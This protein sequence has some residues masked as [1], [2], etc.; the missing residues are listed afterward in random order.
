MR[1]ALPL[2]LVCCAPCT[3]AQGPSVHPYPKFEVFAGYSAIETNDHSLQFPDIGPVG[4]LDFDEKGK[5]FETAVIFNLNR[6]VGI[7]GDFSAHFSQNQFA[8]PL[9]LPCNRAPC[10]DSTQPGTIDPRLFDFLVGPE[11]KLRNRTRFTPFVHTLF[12]LAHSTATFRTTGST[13][14]LS[15]T[16]GETGFAMAFGGGMDVRI[17]RRVSF[18]GFLTYSQAFVG[19]TA[20][21][22][23]KVNSIGWSSGVLFH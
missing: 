5:G 14:N 16:D 18:R 11:L 17:I 3:R 22:S 21:P 4:N 2:L 6:Y 7:M 23:Q 10:S 13:I 20:L 1:V 9:A 8:V 15:R 19:A 12:G